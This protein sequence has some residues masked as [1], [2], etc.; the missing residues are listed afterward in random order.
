MIAN[1]MEFR[2]LTFDLSNSAWTL[3]ALGVTFESG[4]AEQLREPRTVDE[5]AAACRSLTRGRIEACLAVAAA[6]G[7]AGKD[8]DRWSIAEGAKPLLQPPMRAALLGEIRTTLMQ[9]LAAI[10]DAK[11][12]ATPGWRHTNPLL[13]QAQGD[14]SAMFAPMFKMNIV[15]M[16]G[17]LGARLDAPGARILDVG[18]GVGALAIAFARVFPQASVVGLDPYDVPLALARER[19]KG[20]GLEGRVELRRMGAEDL[21]DEGAF[22]LAWFPSF[23]VPASTLASAIARVRAALRPGGWVLFPIGSSAGDARQRAVVSFVVDGWG[24]AALSPTEAEAALKNAGFSQVR[25]LPGPPWAPATFAA[26]V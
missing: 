3:A 19:V 15:G 10:D 24:G 25:T 9:S 11:G 21:K 26:Q 22:D 6:I 18:V 1:P 5:L 23:F 14:A 17:D 7:L 4:L 16:L 8:A 12:E 13:L 2:A 20:A